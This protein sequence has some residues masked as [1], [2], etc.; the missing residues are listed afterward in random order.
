MPK[1]SFERGESVR[2]ISGPFRDLP[3]T[4][5]EV[6]PEMHMLKVIVSIFGRATPVELSFL[7]VEKGSSSDEGKFS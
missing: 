5:E 6:N 7:E 3:G 1:F 2:I 4:V